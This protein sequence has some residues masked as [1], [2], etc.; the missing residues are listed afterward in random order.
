MTAAAALLAGTAGVGPAQAAGK[1]VVVSPAWGMAKFD[2]R[3]DKLIAWDKKADGVGVYAQG[4]WNLG[5][6]PGTEGDSV[7]AEGAG[8]MNI[9]RMHIPEGRK[10]AVRVCKL[11]RNDMFYGCS[12]WHFGRA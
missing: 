8:D 2:H 5:G 12:A 1:D 3:G 7:V 4:M 6:E 10:V 11:S 9:V